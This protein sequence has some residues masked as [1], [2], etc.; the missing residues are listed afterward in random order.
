MA[1]LLTIDHVGHRGDGVAIE[2]SQ[3]IFVPY[4]LAG[5]TVEVDDV[6]GNHPDRR[7]LLRVAQESPERIAPFCPHFGVCGGCAIQHW[8][9]APYHAWKRN[10]V[11]E[12]LAQA[13]IAADV[14][15]LIDAHG[16]G[17]RRITLH[18]RMGP[19][20]VLKVGY[21]AAGSHDIIP[22]DRCPILDPAL[23]GA[24]EA[25][26]ATAEPLT[27][28]GK[29]LDIQVTATVNGLDI[30][31]RGSGA[32]PTSLITTLSRVA[33]KHRLA[34]L[35]R[36]G[37]LVLQRGSPEIA[38]GKAKVVLPPG[39]FLQATVKGEEMLAALVR[40]HCGR[41]KH[42]A[43]LFCGVGP[44]A[45]RLAEK[46]RIAAFDSDTGAITAL[47]KA[48]QS[49]P[50]L[51]PLKAEARDLFRRPLMPQELRDYDAVVF[52]PPRQGAQA[53]VTQLAASKVPVIVAVSCNAATFAR[54]AKILIDG[55]YKIAAV[56]PV[57]QFR[58]TAHVELVA[59]FAR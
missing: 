10:I 56:T 35:T 49:T 16:A 14:T 32:L 3:S 12:T 48:A 36:H 6:P 7:R 11:V 58:H 42:I 15:A 1:E 52:D 18:G 21:A 31:V 38:I 40:E 28:I 37:E 24:L 29:P 45:L 26:W 30:D 9:D 39:S 20:E 44:F 25:A 19:H 50:G 55:G 17:R 27:A 4:A 34:R 2:G 33:Q 46:A 57:D 51:K 47:Q 13:K 59:R 5:E 8:N 43:D 53:Q 22:V 41:A 23:D 54:D